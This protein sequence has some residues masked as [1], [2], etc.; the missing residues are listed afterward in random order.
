V[1]DCEILLLSLE[2]IVADNVERIQQIKL[3][4]LA[5]AIAIHV[6][7]AAVILTQVAD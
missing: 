7:T 1:R 6:V 5:T 2:P 4:R 3:M